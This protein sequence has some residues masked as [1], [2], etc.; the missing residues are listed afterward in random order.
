MM[1][2]IIIPA[3]NEELR[4]RRTVKDYTKFFKRDYEFVVVCDGNDKTAEIVK[5]MSKYDK[6]IR[7]IISKK[8]LGKGGGIYKGFD[9]A[10]GETIGFTD[11]DEGVK[12]SEY[13]KLL[14]YLE[15]YDC[16]IASRRAKGSNIIKNRPWHIIVV[17]FIFNRMVNL[18][19]DLGIKDT[20]CGA[21]II[22]KYVYNS[23]KHDVFLKG[24]EFDVEF[25][26]RIKKAGFKIKE[27][28]IE[29]SHDPRSKTNVKNHPNLLYQT[30]RLRLH[31]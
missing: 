25:L 22:K 24:F 4:I 2:S 5:K 3:Y 23:I 26:W 28:P 30:I 21:K 13:K 6:R 10:R 31:G 11:A 20:Q 9:S 17:S 19:F 18:L 8:R 1:H 7:V 29:W 16:T 14:S 27:V 12:P 15:E